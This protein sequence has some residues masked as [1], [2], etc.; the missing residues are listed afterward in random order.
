MP[1]PPH[2]EV[3][4]L[5]A[6]LSGQG[7]RIGWRERG[8]SLRRSWPSC[9]PGGCAH[10]PRAERRGGGARDRGDGGDVSS[11]A[12]RVRRPDVGSGAPDEG[13]RE[14]A[15]AGRR[16]SRA[17]QAH[18]GGGRAGKP[19]SPAR[20]RA[21][22]EHIKAKPTISERRARPAPLGQHRST[23][24]ARCRGPRRGGR[25]DGRHHRPCTRAW[26]PWL[27]QDPRPPACG[28][29]G[30]ERQA[31]GADLAARGAQGASQATQKGPAL[32]GRRVTCP[33]ATGAP[34][35]RLGLRPCRGPHP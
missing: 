35:P 30:G 1:D 19:L 33:F 14:P 11:L 13:A 21:C 32:A 10:I 26:P 27:P 6:W 7:G 8:T 18:S 2:C 17:R 28:G 15:A 22:V 5:G 31:R 29:L 12:P 16:G 4:C 25:A 23:R 20:R 34:Q 3:V 9:G 24:A